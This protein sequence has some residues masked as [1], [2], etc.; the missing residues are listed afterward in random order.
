MELNMSFFRSL[1]FFLMVLS[2]CYEGIYISEGN[3]NYGHHNEKP[4]IGGYDVNCHWNSGYRDYRWIFQAWVDHP[5]GYEEVSDVFVNIYDGNKLVD[6]LYL[7]YDENG[8]WELLILEKN[9]ELWCGNHY[10]I[11]FYAIDLRDNWDYLT[12]YPTY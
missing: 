8:Y 5:Q 9:T 3:N 12:V 11:D 1:I 6:T 10:E 2:G 4:L 7:S